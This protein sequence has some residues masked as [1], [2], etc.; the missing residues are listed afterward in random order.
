MNAIMP[1]TT[2]GSVLQ[3]FCRAVL[4]AVPV[5][6]TVEDN[7]T[8]GAKLA[9]AGEIGDHYLYFGF[10][11]EGRMSL[12]FKEELTPGQA[13]LL[14][15]PKKLKNFTNLSVQKIAKQITVL[16]YRRMPALD[17]K[18]ADKAFLTKLASV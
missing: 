4:S 17:P 16:L 11:P 3:A 18:N 14:W 13:E 8:V 10:D 12:Y 1:Q 2:V 9:I 6:G 7:G 5:A 15:G